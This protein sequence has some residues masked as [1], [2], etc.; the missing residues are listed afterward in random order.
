MYILRTALAVYRLISTGT[1][2]HFKCVGTS[3]YV[4]SHPRV[5]WGPWQQHLQA[6]VL[7]LDLVDIWTNGASSS[8]PPAM[9]ACSP[10]AGLDG[11]SS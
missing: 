2:A 11:N 9:H 5:P 1:L 3:L 6:S 10:R 7:V 8:P 4:A